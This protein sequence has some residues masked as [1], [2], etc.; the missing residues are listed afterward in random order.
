VGVGVL[1]GAS[2]Q[3]NIVIRIRLKVI[4]RQ[5]TGCIFILKPFLFGG[6]GHVSL[7]LR[8]CYIKILRLNKFAINL[9]Q[10]AQGFWWNLLNFCIFLPF[11]CT[12]KPAWAAQPGESAM[13]NP[14]EPGFFYSSTG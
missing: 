5:I 9:T 4:E 7:G 10:T 2:A 6:I 13:P 14:R 3:D 12:E 1:V 8:L 11:C